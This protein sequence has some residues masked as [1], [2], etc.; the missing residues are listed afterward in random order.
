MIGETRAPGAWLCLAWKWW[1]EREVQLCYG[2]LFVRTCGWSFLCPFHE[3]RR[4]NGLLWLFLK[5]SR[6]LQERGVGC[7][8]IAQVKDHSCFSEEPLKISYH[9]FVQFISD[10]HPLDPTKPIWKE[11]VS[12]NYQTHIEKGKIWSK[13]Q[14]QTNKP[15]MNS[16]FGNTRKYRDNKG[17]RYRNPM[18]PNSPCKRLSRQLKCLPLYTRTPTRSHFLCLLN[19]ISAQFSSYKESVWNLE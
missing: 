9:I 16:S 3:Q 2:I 13:K 10:F 1:V 5:E 12:T 6:S 15:N 8:I 4:S 7:R 19:N 18:S 11:N 17:R 14:T